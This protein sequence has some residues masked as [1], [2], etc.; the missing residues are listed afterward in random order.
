MKRKIAAVL[1]FNAYAYVFVLAFWGATPFLFHGQDLSHLREQGLPFS[2][3]DWGFDDHYLWRFIAAAV[4]TALAAF[5]C[6]AIA[7][8]RG[9]RVALI[10]NVPSVIGWIIFVWVYFFSFDDFDI[11]PDQ[12]TKELMTAYGIVSVLAIPM[13][14]W[15]AV[16]FGEI[17]QRAQTGSSNPDGTLGVADWHWGWMWLPLSFYGY[18]IV[19]SIATLVAMLFKIW[20][21]K[22]LLGGVLWLLG[23]GIIAAWITPLILSYQV[24]VGGGRLQDKS[25]VQR[26]AIALAI[27]VGGYFF[28]TAVAFVFGWILDE[29]GF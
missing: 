3:Y 4:S 14:G 11:N 1:A 19:F 2:S 12:K 17:G 26:G 25:A 27:L 23:I 13:T 16:K 28:A 18:R 22:S 9:G 21:G 10:A 8:E 5:I 15:L 24:L 7:R 20:L 6:G 29:F